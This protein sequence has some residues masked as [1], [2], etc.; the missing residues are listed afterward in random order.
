MGSDDVPLLIGAI[1]HLDPAGLRGCR[2]VVSIRPKIDPALALGRLA[3]LH[4]DLAP[5]RVCRAVRLARHRPNILSVCLITLGRRGMDEVRL[6]R[7]GEV[8][9]L[10]RIST[11]KVYELR[12]DRIISA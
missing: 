10:L 2:R 5:L 12:R 11:T 4:K 8:A 6:L 7:I 3:R 9:D 1:D